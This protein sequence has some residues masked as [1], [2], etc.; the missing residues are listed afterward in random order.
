MTFLPDFDDPRPT[1]ENPEK[2]AQTPKKPDFWTPIFNEIL[3]K[4]SPL[5]TKFAQLTKKYFNQQKYHKI[6]K[7]L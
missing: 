3:P 2:P 1:P 6:Y 4:I 7:K 5:L